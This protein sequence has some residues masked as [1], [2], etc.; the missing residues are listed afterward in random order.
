MGEASSRRWEIKYKIKL[1]HSI[2]Q[3]KKFMISTSFSDF[4]KIALKQNIITLKACF[5]NRIRPNIKYMALCIN[6]LISR[7][8]TWTCNEGIVQVY[9]N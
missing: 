1:L 3:N 4:G 9:M 5:D 8:G 2:F 7:S 6:C